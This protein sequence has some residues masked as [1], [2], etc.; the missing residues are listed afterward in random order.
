MN[1]LMKVDDMY[2][3]AKRI[4]MI[5]RSY[6]LFFNPRQEVYE[7][8]DK[9]N[10][11]GSFCLRIHPSELDSRVIGR[12]FET[13]RE[14]MKKLFEQIE[15]QNRRLEQSKLEQIKQDAS[16]HFDAIMD[17]AKKSREEISGRQIQRIIEKNKGV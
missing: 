8:H 3:I 10:K 5:N 9:S 12:L 17:Y 15:V 2:G 11:R 13:R 4:K 14:N 1:E 7:I 16:D 6:E